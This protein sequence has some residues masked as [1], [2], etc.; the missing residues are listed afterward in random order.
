MQKIQLLVH[1]IKRLNDTEK[2]VFTDY[3]ESEYLYLVS[4]RGRKQGQAY[5]WGELKQFRRID[6]VL[7][8]ADNNKD[9]LEIEDADFDFLIGKLKGEGFLDASKDIV[10]IHVN[11]VERF[12]QATPPKAP[13]K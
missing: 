9:V 13:G 7:A 3:K 11:L 1:R 5:S 10:R 6:E 8:K 12:E 2:L 4:R